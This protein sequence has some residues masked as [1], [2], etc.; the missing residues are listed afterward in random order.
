MSDKIK[1]VAVL[2][3][4]GDAP[5]MNAAIRSVV[6][7]AISRNLKV[8]GI[9]KGYNGLLNEEIIDMEPRNVSDIIQRGGTVLGTARCLEFK[10]A[11]YQKRGADICRKHGIDG[12]VVIGGDGSY[13]GGA[14]AFQAGDQH[15]GN[16][17][18]HRPGYRVYRV[19]H[20]F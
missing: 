14:G 13:R 9:K 10:K 1:T 17:G 3:S 18:N 5:G 16:P 15:R 7:T 20:R 4:G 2:T 6:R 19:Y 11:E 8:K 12:I